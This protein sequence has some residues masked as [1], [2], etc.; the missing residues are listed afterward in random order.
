MTRKIIFDTDPGVDDAAALLLAHRHP[1]LD[2]IGVT[3]I[4]GN[5]DIDDV[6]RN[7]LWLRE[8]FGFDAPVARGAALSLSG[9]AGP[10]PE[11]IHGVDG[12]GG[13]APASVSEEP[14]PR[15]AHVL[16][17]DLARKAGGD[18]TIVAVGRLTN[19]ALALMHDEKLPNYIRDVIIMG[20]AFGG[21]NGNVTPAAEANIIGDPVAADIVFGANWTVHAVGL[22]V[23]R[24]V[25]MTE[26]M[27]AGVKSGDTAAKLVRDASKLYSRY[28]DRFGIDGF[29]VH[30]S[31]AVACAISPE[32]FTFREGPVRVVREGIARGQTILRDVDTFYP[33]GAWDNRP[34]HKVAFEVDAKGVLNLLESALQQ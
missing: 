25:M 9:D 1:A 7:A 10:Y 13:L 5:A 11:F 29:Y 22:D 16:I 23:T 26:E 27:F 12:L 14:D 15:P 33:P 19:L 17:S 8:V 4:F 6:T 28:H 3:T 20:G 31:S 32:L 24:Q 30:D 2:L 18:V 34:S 21:G